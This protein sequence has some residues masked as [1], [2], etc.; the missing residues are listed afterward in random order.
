MYKKREL[1]V[2]YTWQ[3]KKCI[4]S[5]NLSGGWIRNLGFEIGDMVNV[6]MIENKLVIENVN[7]QGNE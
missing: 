7:K 3:N 2:S 1:K 5:I 4:P 6:E